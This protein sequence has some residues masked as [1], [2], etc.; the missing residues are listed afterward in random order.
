M[1]HLDEHEILND[2]QHGFR[3]KRSCETQLITTIN[4]FSET[5]NKKGQTDATLLDFSKAFDKVDHQGLI[6]KLRNYGVQDKLL[7]WTKSFL[8]GRSQKVIV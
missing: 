4:D 3:Q 1:D 6:L 7:D 5:L 2:I 8:I